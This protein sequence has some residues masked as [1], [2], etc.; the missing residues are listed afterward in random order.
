MFANSPGFICIGNSSG[1]KGVAIAS[2]CHLPG[3]IQL[4][5]IGTVMCRLFVL[6]E[7]NLNAHESKHLVSG[8]SG[9]LPFTV[10]SH[11][12]LE[13]WPTEPVASHEVPHAV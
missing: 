11:T 7:L 10:Y 5:P 13:S 3:V 8:Q 6:G 12:A 4:L 9:L 2:N 1:I